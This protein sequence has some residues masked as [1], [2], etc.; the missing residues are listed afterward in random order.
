MKVKEESEK[1]GLKLNIQKTTNRLVI[2][3]L[4]RSKHLLISW[5]QSSSAVILEPPKIKSDQHR[6]HIKKQRHYF[7]NRGLS[8]QSYGFFSS[9]VWMWELD[10][11]EGWAPKNWCL[12][13]VVLE[14]ILESLLDCKEI[15][16]RMRQLDGITNSM[17]MSLSKF[18]ETVKDRESWRAAVH[19]VAKN[20]TWLSD[21]R[22]TTTFW[23][24]TAQDLGMGSRDSRPSAT[25]CPSWP[26]PNQTGLH[27][28][29]SPHWLLGNLLG[30]NQLLSLSIHCPQCQC[31]LL[32]NGETVAAP[33]NL[34]VWDARAQCRKGCDMW[35]NS[36]WWLSLSLL[37]THTH[38]HTRTRT[39]TPL[40]Q[41]THAP[42][43]PWDLTGRHRTPGCHGTTKISA[44]NQPLLCFSVWALQNSI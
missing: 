34:P 24:Q 42:S 37:H 32:G 9:H 10:H 19:G 27:R 15:K 18:W 20:R 39:H 22:T 6:Q 1:A 38:T 43:W 11:K 36:M 40:P 16:Q 26:W 5:L 44:Q 14:K 25:V 3:F 2:I 13:T 29:Q 21:W 28:G 33:N 12:W 31:S 4:P 41:K 7:A 35:L 23:E 30:S 8:S 17:D